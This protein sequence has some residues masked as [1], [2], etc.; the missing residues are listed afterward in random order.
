M[1]SSVTAVGATSMP[2]V[3]KI[4]LEDSTVMTLPAGVNSRE[5]CL[6][7]T[8]SMDPVIRTFELYRPTA[9]VGQTLALNTSN[10]IADVES[11][12]AKVTSIDM[13]LIV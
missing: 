2:G 5:V 9:T 7:I 4:K 10:K 8:S 13:I 1:T 6:F 11:I 12:L 3:Y